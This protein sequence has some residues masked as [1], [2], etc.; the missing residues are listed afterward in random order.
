MS[1]AADPHL[2]L[3]ANADAIDASECVPTPNDN[4]TAPVEI[5]EHAISEYVIAT[6]V[7]SDAEATPSF[8]VKSNV[9][10]SALHLPTTLNVVQREGPE[11]PP[12]SEELTLRALQFQ[13]ACWDAGRPYRR[14]AA[15]ARGMYDGDFER[16]D[17]AQT[18]FA[19]AVRQPAEAEMVGVG[20]RPGGEVFGLTR[21]T[22][23][24]LL[25]QPLALENIP[26]MNEATASKFTPA[27]LTQVSLRVR[28][29]GAPHLTAVHTTQRE[30]SYL[31]SPFSA[32]SV[33]ERAD[34]A[35]P[36]TSPI[37]PANAVLQS[38][39]K[40]RM[41][42]I[43]SGND[44]STGSN[45]PPPATPA[46]TREQQQQRP[47][48]PFAMAASVDPKRSWDPIK[49]PCSF[50]V[51]SCSSLDHSM[52]ALSEQGAPYAYVE[53]PL[54][55]P[56]V[57]D[58]VR[59]NSGHVDPD[60]VS[61]RVTNKVPIRSLLTVSCGNGH[62]VWG[63]SEDS[64]DFRR[65]VARVGFT[66][67]TPNGT[68]WVNMSE[69][70]MMN[71]PTA[72]ERAQATL[73]RSKSLFVRSP[74]ATPPADSTAS[75]GEPVVVKT[76][77]HVSVGFDGSVWAIVA[78]SRVDGNSDAIVAEFPQCSIDLYNA[79][80]VF[81]TSAWVREGARG[82]SLG[83]R[84]MPL[85]LHQEQ[86]DYHRPYEV[87]HQK[88]NGTGG[89]NVNATHF[90]QLHHGTFNQ[91]FAIIAEDMSEYQQGV[92]HLYERCG[93]TEQ[94]LTG[95]CWRKLLLDP[96]PRGMHGL[97]TLPVDLR[98]LPEDP[99]VEP[100]T[101]LITMAVASDG[102]VWAVNDQ[103]RLID[104]TACVARARA[105]PSSV[106]LH[107]RFQGIPNHRDTTIDG[108]LYDANRADLTPMIQ[109]FL[110]WRQTQQQQS[111]PPPSASPLPT[112]AGTHWQLSTEYHRLITSVMV[113]L[114]NATLRTLF[115]DA[116][117]ELLAKIPSPQQKLYLC[118]IVAQHAGG[119]Q[120]SSASLPSHYYE[121]R[122]QWQLRGPSIPSIQLSLQTAPH[123][124]FDALTLN[125][126]T[127]QVAESVRWEWTPAS[128]YVIPTS[129]L[130]SATSGTSH[131]SI[132]SVLGGANVIHQLDAS[133]PTLTPPLSSWLQI[134]VDSLH[135]SSAAQHA[136]EF[137]ESVV[138][139]DLCRDEN[140]FDACN[141]HDASLRTF[142]QVQTRR[143]TIRT[144]M[145]LCG[146][147]RTATVISSVPSLGTPTPSIVV[148]CDDFLW[149]GG[150]QQNVYNTH[151]SSYA[152]SPI[153]PPLSSIIA[154]VASQSFLH[155]P[156]NFLFAD[157]RLRSLSSP[158]MSIVGD[159][160]ASY[161]PSSSSRLFTDLLDLV[162]GCARSL[163]WKINSLALSNESLIVYPTEHKYRST[164]AFLRNR[165]DQET[166]TFR[167]RRLLGEG[168]ELLPAVA[169]RPGLSIIVESAT[170]ELM[171]W[172][173][174]CAVTKATGVSSENA[175]VFESFFRK[176]FTLTSVSG[177][178]TDTPLEHRGSELLL[179]C[180]LTDALAAASAEP[181]VTVPRMVSFTTKSLY[182]FDLLA[183]LR[184]VF[185]VLPSI[186]G[187]GI[188]TADMAHNCVAMELL[189]PEFVL[190]LHGASHS[191][192]ATFSQY[193]TRHYASG[194]LHTVP[195][196]AATNN[197]IG[198][199]VSLKRVSIRCTLRFQVTPPALR[200][201]SDGD[202]EVERV[203]QWCRDLLPPS[204][205]S[206]GEIVL[207]DAATPPLTT[208]ATTPALKFE[209]KSTSIVNW[210]SPGGLGSGVCITAPSVEVVF[211]PS[212]TT[213]D[214]ST[215]AL[216][217][218]LELRA[219]RFSG[220]GVS[221]GTLFEFG[222]IEYPVLMQGGSAKAL[223]SF[224]HMFGPATL[225][226]QRRVLPLSELIRGASS[227]AAAEHNASSSHGNGDDEEVQMTRRGMF[228][229]DALDSTGCRFINAEYVAGGPTVIPH[230]LVPRDIVQLPRQGPA[231][232]DMPLPPLVAVPPLQAN[233]NVDNV[234]LSHQV[235]RLH[236]VLEDESSVKEVDLSRSL[237]FDFTSSSVDSANDAT[238]QQSPDLSVLSLF[239]APG[240]DVF[241]W[242][243]VKHVSSATGANSGL[244][245]EGSAAAHRS[246]LQDPVLRYGDRVLLV[247]PDSGNCV[248][249]G[250]KN[251]PNESGFL[252]VLHH[253]QGQSTLV[254]G[255]ERSSGTVVD[256]WTPLQRGDRFM[257]LSAAPSEM[258]MNEDNTASLAFLRKL[259]ALGSYNDEIVASVDAPS[260]DLTRNN[261]SFA[262]HIDGVDTWMAS[263]VTARS[264]LS[265]DST[266]ALVFGQNAIATAVAAL[267]STNGD[268]D[269]NSEATT[270]TSATSRALLNVSG[271]FPHPL[272]FGNRPYNKTA[273]IYLRDVNDDSRG[274]SFDIVCSEE[275]RLSLHQPDDGGNA[276]PPSSLALVG[277]DESGSSPPTTTTSTTLNKPKNKRSHQHDVTFRLRD[278][279]IFFLG[280]V[281]PCTGS[282]LNDGV[283]GVAMGDVV[284]HAVAA[285]KIPTDSS[286]RNHLGQSKGNEDATTA[287]S[288][289]G[290]TLDL[291]VSL[292]VPLVRKSLLVDAPS[293]SISLPC[294]PCD[295]GDRF[296]HGDAALA[297]PTLLGEFRC[298]GC[299]EHV[300]SLLRHTI[301][302]MAENA[303]RRFDVKA[304][305]A[306][307][308][309]LSRQ[310]ELQQQHVYVLMDHHAA[311]LIPVENA[312]DEEVAERMQE[313][314]NVIKR[315][316]ALEEKISAKPHK[317]PL[318]ERAMM[319]LQEEMYLIDIAL[320]A[321]QTVHR[322]HAMSLGH[323]IES[324]SNENTK[325]SQL[326][327]EMAE[328]AYQL[329]SAQRFASIAATTSPADGAANNNISALTAWA[330]RS[331]RIH[332]SCNP[333]SEASGSTASIEFEFEV[334]RRASGILGSPDVGYAPAISSLS[335]LNPTKTVVSPTPQHYYFADTTRGAQVL[336]QS[337]GGSKTSTTQTTE[338]VVFHVPIDVSDVS[339]TNSMPLKSMDHFAALVA[340]PVAARL[341]RDVLAA[342][343][344]NLYQLT[345]EELTVVAGASPQRD[346]LSL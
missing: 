302:Q 261:V 80:T 68:D 125:H 346:A 339:H 345:Q 78:E 214:A 271:Y 324:I 218:S 216:D 40:K 257:L 208:S 269:D 110:H 329:K 338:I 129:L 230:N 316:E 133:T 183:S 177:D 15:V 135:P 44:S 240:A 121:L 37:P 86:F 52:W 21:H 341:V 149:A 26:F 180:N 210:T 176:A 1:D 6:V 99:E 222:T 31:T 220:Q 326:R 292:E 130:S 209:G 104:C 344:Q 97:L 300:E 298:S 187:G 45:T 91:V 310:A 174:D 122:F 223:G 65:C 47:L 312:A 73:K 236:P 327:V 150:N 28:N 196:A 119:D 13:Q 123:V 248:G 182:G 207:F 25:T 191:P 225:R 69:G 238:P 258:Y 277:G 301:N 189:N 51:I 83:Q 158:A 226:V 337:G 215:S 11:Y 184:S 307:W 8:P 335:L 246:T 159:S 330:L 205:V 287:C 203:Q 268:D 170:D 34:A 256:G 62:S 285:W 192:Q 202:D 111:P 46:T 289:H 137:V 286:L 42:E 79:S 244:L 103:K 126:E 18:P 76:F 117:S 66:A 175:K 3:D 88:K 163:R 181:V 81:R 228:M 185:D 70:I 148:L 172:V 290:R 161:R 53:V 107:D 198:G 94:N 250:W 247:D 212:S 283:A 221:H 92:G 243:F 143:T 294:P 195:A 279:A 270:T 273:S 206:N 308:K 20:V 112:T 87:Q 293:P 274:C 235:L 296:Y 157:Q 297:T 162:D 239:S 144:K 282:S 59:V 61:G 165:A 317:A 267:P 266:S 168:S 35:R 213:T 136:V 132:F 7:V 188:I 114:D 115:P 154:P 155:R 85:A 171:G 10:C 342:P 234:I 306:Q 75:L 60:S 251:G 39:L 138:H 32:A 48:D 145:M 23:R 280:A 314:K 334:S 167:N 19:T 30:T 265:L 164:C 102:G 67:D 146:S 193:D 178:R 90:L 255:D 254:Q 109:A 151:P 118:E 241:K 124:V 245:A 156:D 199:A 134:G 5:T 281:M 322:H 272:V 49:T 141:L 332:G 227:A 54:S 311:S 323:D 242:I 211:S 237:M 36:I 333:A 100:P 27:S 153:C 319:A 147:C 340:Y 259:E 24:E 64:S 93:I 276:P 139:R 229:T 9:V 232:P 71:P 263:S 295:G 101:K 204:F 41:A 4:S 264:S 303:P 252:W 140:E 29:Y 173:T 275:T 50:R 17:A 200:S 253:G 14:D 38:P 2:E 331:V 98:L 260:S 186:S 74:T 152:A 166:R 288:H 262:L 194:P 108:D 304:L 321:A 291:H 328:V 142:R 131:R 57:R 318:Y 82:R 95:D 233:T 219:L 22:Y 43:R 33:K 179:A 313:L 128:A 58:W 72:S 116:D 105:H 315:Q 231:T 113:L 169:L 16:E 305:T 284:L 278:A 127:A 63:I 56:P 249:N 343:L 320:R 106:I 89:T 336:M 309:A 190:E 325:L 96:S 84:W 197:S 120:T 299:I 160:G 217:A 55:N 224:I 12:A 77:L 201:S